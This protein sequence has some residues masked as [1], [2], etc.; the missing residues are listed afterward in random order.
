M[1]WQDFVFGLMGVLLLHA[2]HPALKDPQKPPV[3]TSV[4]TAIILFVC[5]MTHTTLGLW[6]TAAVT[7]MTSMYWV[8]LAYQRARQKKGGKPDESSDLL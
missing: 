1:V 5:A 6:G 2:L 8:I 4:Q 3:R 7:A